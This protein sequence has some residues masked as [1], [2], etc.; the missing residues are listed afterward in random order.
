MTVTNKLE[1]NLKEVGVAYFK[2][3]S[4]NLLEGIRGKPGK[5]SVGTVCVL[6]EIRTWDPHE[7]N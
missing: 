3:L 2:I 7:Y 6:T 1:V 5:S 4:G